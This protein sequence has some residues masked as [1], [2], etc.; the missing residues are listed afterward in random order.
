M[1]EHVDT[2]PPLPGIFDECKAHRYVAIVEGFKSYSG[3]GS[4]RLSRDHVVPA[5]KGKSSS[6]KERSIPTSGEI[7][8]FI[9]AFL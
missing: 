9:I 2:W 8:L 5:M 4:E 3:V 7:S 6:S 1:H